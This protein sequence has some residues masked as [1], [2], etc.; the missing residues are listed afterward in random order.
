MANTLVKLVIWNFYHQLPKY[1]EV[2]AKIGIVLIFTHWLLPRTVHL[3]RPGRF[4][5]LKRKNR[6]IERGTQQRRHVIDQNMY[7][8][9]ERHGVKKWQQSSAFLKERKRT[10]PVAELHL[11]REVAGRNLPMPHP[12]TIHVVLTTR[13]LLLR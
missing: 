10:V 9:T 3:Y 8:L 1:F 4:Y 2:L 12:L 6:V 11:R 13:V 5:L 7:S